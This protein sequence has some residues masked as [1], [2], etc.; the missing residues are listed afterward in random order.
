M[1]KKSILFAKL[2][3]WILADIVMK[4]LFG[5]IFILL[6][7]ASLPFIGVGSK[8]MPNENGNN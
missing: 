7:I 2:I 4:L 5:T 3:F 1:A 6:Y 8:E